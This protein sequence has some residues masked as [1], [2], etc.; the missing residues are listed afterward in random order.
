MVEARQ[1]DLSPAKIAQDNRWVKGPFCGRRTRRYC[2]PLPLDS[3][4]LASP[5]RRYFN[6][7]SPPSIFEQDEINLRWLDSKRTEG[8]P[9]RGFPGCHVA[10]N[11]PRTSRNGVIL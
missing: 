4:H 1:P 9:E 8:T 5:C 10:R 3:G 7:S 11:F 2:R 6:I